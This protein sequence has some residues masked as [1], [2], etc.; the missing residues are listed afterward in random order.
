MGDYSYDALGGRTLLE[1]ARTPHLDRLAQESTLGLLET[2][3]HGF[4]P[5]SDVGNMT[6]LGYDPRRYYTGRAPLEAASMGISLDQHDIAIRC[7]L[8]TLSDDHKIL[9]DY[10][11]G[12][13]P[14]ELA[15]RLISTLNRELGTKE[16]EFHPGVSYRHLLVWRNAPITPTDLKLTPPHEIPDQPIEPY[17]PNIPALEE[18]IR[19]SW[20]LLDGL[21]A[22]SI[23]LWGAGQA[24]SMP[25]LRERFGIT[26]SVISAVDLIKGLGVYAGLAV[27]SVPGATG[28][29]DT[30]YAG[31]VHAALQSLQEHEFVYVHIEAPDE[32]GHQ[33][34][35][36][37]KLR[38]IEDF[39]EKVI[40]P[41]LEGLK[42][43][44]ERF[45]VLVTTDHYTPVRDRVH[46]AAPVPF[47]LY[48]STQAR[49]QAHLAFHE[50][51]AQT[52]GV[53]I[54]EGHRLLGLLLGR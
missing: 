10:S 11:A 45:S 31:K 32:C 25:T 26:G 4:P 46:V 18:L 9:R 37:L 44:Y 2:I 15:R 41:L 8:V 7:N 34:R 14:T 22:N 28:Y 13:I 39:D 50:K 20:D 48:Q 16:F 51:A 47:A 19:R 24:P 29:L 36:D 30:N 49:R 27:Q 54:A 12:H 17:L 52:T 21:R 42:A 43:N 40:G 35:L 1:Y 53:Y 3:P 38:A 5:G 23:W 33:G 6:L